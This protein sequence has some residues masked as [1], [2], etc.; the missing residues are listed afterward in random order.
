MKPALA[1]VFVLTLL[2]SGCDLIGQRLS[3]R[4]GL[5]NIQEKEA[6]ADAE[7]RECRYTLEAEGV[8]GPT[9]TEAKAAKL[10]AKWV[11]T[12]SSLRPA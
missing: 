1:T 5:E 11:E 4:L 12:L 9:L 7:G 3:Q 10:A 8:E 2:L 6:K